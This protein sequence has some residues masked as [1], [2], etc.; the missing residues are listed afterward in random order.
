VPVERTSAHSEWPQGTADGH[1][2]AD[3]GLGAAAAVDTL[4][5]DRLAR[6]DRAAERPEVGDGD[7]PWVAANQ[8]PTIGG[9]G[10]GS[11]YLARSTSMLA[12]LS[13]PYGHVVAC[14]QRAAPFDG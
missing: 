12:S 2:L 11:R 13:K 5:P 8:L 4:R 1:A 10:E 9:I 3:F 7:L 14:G 6:R